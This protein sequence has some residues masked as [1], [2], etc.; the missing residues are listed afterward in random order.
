V[1]AWYVHG[2]DLCY[3]VDSTNGLLCYHADAQGN[4]IA[5]TDENTNLV[6]QYAY[7]PYGRSL[8]SSNYQSPTSNPYLFV[9]SQG[10]QEESDIPSLY[11]MRARYYS[12]EIGIFLSSD[13]VKKIG[14][15]WKPT[16]FAYAANNPLSLSD[17][18]G[19]FIV[20]ILTSVIAQSISIDT[21]IIFRG[22]TVT[23]P[24][25]LARYAAAVAAGATDSAIADSGGEFFAGTLGKV[26]AFATKGVVNFAG[27]ALV[28]ASEGDFNLNTVAS[29]TFVDNAFSSMSLIEQA[30]ASKSL[31]EFGNT[32]FD[33]TKNVIGETLADSVNN[34]LQN[35]AQHASSSLITSTVNAA[36]VAPIVNA[37][38]IKTGSASSNPGG[39]SSSN[40]GGA[41]L[42]TMTYVVKPGDTLGNIGY[43]HGTTATAIGAANGITDLGLIH[44]GEELKIP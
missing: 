9:G 13:P 1:T 20:G 11:F 21:D 19:E 8:G 4:V 10:V 17:P 43:A 24:E 22:K 28:S 7:T 27:N 40:T 32:L 6:V 34:S 35:H 14:P 16:A 38:S 44:P 2:P 33:F 29:E 39:Y 5:L 25:L 31:T 26:G 41:S 23:M 37:S 3:R 15:G 12:A 42:N 36:N 30:N 18:K